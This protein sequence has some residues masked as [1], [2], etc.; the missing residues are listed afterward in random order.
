MHKYCK[1]FKLSLNLN[2]EVNPAV[3]I[4]IVLFNVIENLK[5]TFVGSKFYKII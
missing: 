2:Y 3:Y 4:Q 1:S 5:L